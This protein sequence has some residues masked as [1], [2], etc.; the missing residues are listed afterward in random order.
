MVIEVRT[1]SAAAK[2]PLIQIVGLTRAPSIII[3]EP[4]AAAADASEDSGLEHSAPDEQG[5]SEH[6][7][8]GERLEEQDFQRHTGGWVSVSQKLYDAVELILAEGLEDTDELVIR[9][10]DSTAEDITL[11]TPLWAHLPDKDQAA[12]MLSRLFLDGKGFDRPFGI[13][14]LPSSPAAS[15]AAEREAADADA[16]AMGVHLPWNQL[17][18]EGLLAYG[19]R[20]EAAQLTT[21]LMSAVVQCLKDTPLILRA[22]S[23]RDGPRPRRTRRGYRLGAGR[24]LFAD[25]R[26]QHSF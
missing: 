23:C 17:I 26:S 6:S 19:F 2:R 22:L 14:A 8:H 18:G 11:F 9:T 20:A 13:P 4:I 16:V 10:V 12:A 5:D 3:P 1:Q 21:R 7:E 25:A 15:D 24:P